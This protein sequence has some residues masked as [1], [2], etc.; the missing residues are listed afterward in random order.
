MKEFI[1]KEVI[2]RL[3]GLAESVKGTVVADKKDRVLVRGSDG[4]VARIPKS[5]I[6]IF[7][8]V[9]E[10]EYIPI[11][12]M[13][14]EN[15]DIRCLGVRCMKVGNT[16]METDYEAFMKPCPMRQESC[17]KGNLGDL[18]G[19]SSAKLADMMGGTIYGEYP[20]KKE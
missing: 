13:A 2:F 11:H 19:Q 4:K 12:V 16:P 1:G 17:R 5:K 10:D 3:D 9:S 15:K 8:P 7:T 6:V 20:K 18:R 14:C